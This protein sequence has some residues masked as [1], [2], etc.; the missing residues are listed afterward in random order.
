LELEKPQKYSILGLPCN[1]RSFAPHK[2]K[3][4]KISLFSQIHKAVLSYSLCS[5]FK[6]V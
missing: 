5:Q 6:Y 4:S 2:I 1:K 3:F